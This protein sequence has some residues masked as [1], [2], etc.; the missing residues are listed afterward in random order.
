MSLHSGCG[1]DAIVR[2]CEEA[3]GWDVPSRRALK[4]GEAT[5]PSQTQGHLRDGSVK[6]TP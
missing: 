3:T 1:D 5:D 4:G 2:V 6:K